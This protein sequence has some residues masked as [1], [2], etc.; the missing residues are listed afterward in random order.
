MKKLCILIFLSLIFFGCAST[1]NE[2]FG[3]EKFSFNKEEFD[4]TANFE[5]AFI[6]YNFPNDSI[7]SSG[8]LYLIFTNYKTEF[9]IN[10]FKIIDS[11]MQIIKIEKLSEDAVAQGDLFKVYIFLPGGGTYYKFAFENGKLLKYVMDMPEGNQE[12]PEYYLE[13]EYDFKDISKMKLEK[14]KCIK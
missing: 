10:I 12:S 7:Y 3:N 6:N 4:G 8:D 9:G 14:I 13:Q 1:K 2:D 11:S 5:L